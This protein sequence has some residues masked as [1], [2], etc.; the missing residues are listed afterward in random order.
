[1]ST[2]DFPPSTFSR[3]FALEKLI[4]YQ[5]AVDLADVIFAQS[6]AFP[7]GYGFLGNQLNRA[8]LSISA[9]IAEGNGAKRTEE[10][11]HSRM[12]LS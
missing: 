6:E 11:G 1:L 8:I 4:V 7:R 10:R 12:A 2:L 9:N 5:K 3:A